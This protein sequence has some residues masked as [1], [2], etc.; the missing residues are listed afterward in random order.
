MLLPFAWQKDCLISNKVQ[1]APEATPRLSSPFDFL[2]ISGTTIHPTCPHLSLLLLGKHGMSA[3]QGH[4]LLH[5]SCWWRWD[6]MHGVFVWCCRCSSGRGCC[7]DRG[8]TH[9]GRCRR[10]FAFLS[11]FHTS[12][13][14]L[15]SPTAHPLSHAHP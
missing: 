3:S 15:K 7:R 6:V 13:L 14:P 4:R 8:T 1:K 9:V 2:N 10:P 12:I 11:E 5:L